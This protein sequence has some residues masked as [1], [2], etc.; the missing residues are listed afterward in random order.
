MT[1]FVRRRPFL[2]FYVLALVM[3]AAFISVRSFDP[4]AMADMFKTMRTDPWH[5]NIITSFPYV[6]A[7]PVLVTGYLFPLAPTLAAIIVVAIAGGG[8]GLR[9]LFDRF[10][11]WR[12]GVTWREGLLVY[13]MAFAVYL[14]LVG[15]LVILLYMNGPQ[16]GLELM[17]R[18]YGA[19]PVAV[20]TFLVVAPFLGPGGLLEELG[21]RGFAFP[22]LVERLKNPLLAAVVLG[23]LW[24]LWHLPRD[25]PALLSGDPAL[26]KGGGYVGYVY[27]QIGFIW[28]TVIGSIVIAFVFFKTGGSVWAAI[29]VHNFSNEFSVGLT[30]MTKAVTEVGGFTIRPGGVFS[31]T[32]AILIVIFAGS[33][34]GRR[35][36]APA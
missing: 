33:N 1:E 11:P 5:P 7:R 31:T 13:T 30:M 16:S 3:G 24:G 12:E 23:V 29:L 15:F 26:I 25:V 32:I 2:V 35:R 4:T 27:N 22:L 9:R 20:W 8:P 17:L 21:W 6:L 28:G 18:R 14:A 10:R 36:D 19:T 34:L